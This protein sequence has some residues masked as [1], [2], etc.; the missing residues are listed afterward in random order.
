MVLVVEDHG[1]TR[2]AVVK[3]LG[4]EGYLAVGVESGEEGLEYLREVTPELM[5]L[6]CQMPSMDGLEL[7]RA[8]RADDRLARVPVVMF[9][10]SVSYA[11]REEFDHLGVQGW[12]AKGSTDW[13]EI[14]QFAKMY[15]G[16]GV[17]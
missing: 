2:D 13:E 7:L 1:D 14:L 5:L 8:I 16:R 10:A 4:R 17:S 9:T 3:L 12:I 15:A 6:D 11:L